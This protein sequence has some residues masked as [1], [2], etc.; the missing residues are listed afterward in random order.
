MQDTARRHC[1]QSVTVELTM[2]ARI[3]VRGALALVVTLAVA[4]V[5]L[6]P[7]ASAGDAAVAGQ[8]LKAS[9]PA[10]LVQGGHDYHG[11]TLVKCNF[12]G[13]NLSQA[14]FNGATLSAVVFIRA[15]LTGANFS[16]ATFVDSGNPDFPNDFT[17]A[18][19]NLA[20]FV[21]ARFNGLTYFSY[22]SLTSAN[23]SNTDLTNGNAVFGQSLSF[24]ATASAR[25]SFAGTVMNCEFVPQ[26]AAL[27]LTGAKSLTACATQLVGFNFSKAKL[28]GVNLSGIDL[29]NTTWDGADLSGT[30]FQGTT[31]DGATGLNGAALTVLTGALFNQA[32]ARYVDFSAGKLNGA[33]FVGADLEGADFSK[34]DL[35]ADPDTPNGT[36]AHFDRAS[37]KN[38][39]LA[40]ATLNSVTFSYASLFGT[41]LGAPSSQ[42]TLARAGCP[43]SAPRTGGTCS[44][45]SASGANLTD[46][47]FSNAFVYGV[48]FS[49]PATIVNATKFDGAILVSANFSEASF[50]ID[51]SNGGKA[52]TFNG[53][54]LQGVNASGLR[55]SAL[56]G[57]FVDFGVVNDGVARTG[58]ALHLQLS[59]DYT[60]FKNWNG[61]SATPCIRLRYDNA[62]VLPG[63]VG[64]MTCPNG[65]SYPGVGCG[66]RQP[67]DASTPLNPAW[68]GGS[69][70]QAQPPGWYQVDSTYETATSGAAVCNGAAVDPAWFAVSNP[71]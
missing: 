65:R 21:G 17:L 49:T 67:K 13:L 44:C 14:N 24:D 62:S 19:L 23:F 52:P 34:A 70:A 36:A 55:Q 32:S 69:L 47:D 66:V 26:W 4:A 64:N 58:N 63:N 71:P 16:G 40:G 5:A 60:R 54:W 10:S 41:A 8:A 35:S 11:L 6:V 2:S 30:D 45:A 18:N 61:A 68:N 31:L 53:A 48:D 51:P 22:A 29:S 7:A 42:C 39:S 15:N 46:A 37:L 50:Q 59:G 12:N 56:T 1:L 43:S 33:S 9:C 20:K 3:K 57:A 28:A 25:L 38:V 27:D